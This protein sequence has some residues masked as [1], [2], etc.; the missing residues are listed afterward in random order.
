MRCW[1]VICLLLTG[2]LASA[3]SFDSSLARINE[4]KM[5][6]QYLYGDCRITETVDE[7]SAQ[8]EA[9]E[10][11]IWKVAAYCKERQ[12][13]YVQTVDDLPSGAIICLTCPS[14]RSIAYLSKQVLEEEEVTYAAAMASQER[15][16][17]VGRFL[18][19]L[20]KAGNIDEVQNLLW[21]MGPDIEVKY[22]YQQGNDAQRCLLVYFDTPGNL[23]D[24]MMPATENGVRLN[25]ITGARVSPLRYK[26]T[27]LWIYIEG[28]DL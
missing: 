27:P 5:D 3:Q 1:C 18:D 7:T 25:L 23:L 20:K 6:S 14:R 24:I 12:F 9:L 4:I 26:T 28:L 10:E 22:G 2:A 16:V 17:M 11:L 19:R 8:L 13:T 21:E 15:A